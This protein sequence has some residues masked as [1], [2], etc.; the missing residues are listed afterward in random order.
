MAATVCYSALRI[1][2]QVTDSLIPMLDAQQT[3]SVTRAFANGASDSGY[4][5]PLRAAQIQAL[6]EVSNGHYFA[7]FMGF[8]AS[9]GIVVVALFVLVL[10][11]DSFARVAAL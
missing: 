10:E 8:Q 7:A 5:R 11:V 9:M 3:S 4:F 2:L 1:P 6:L